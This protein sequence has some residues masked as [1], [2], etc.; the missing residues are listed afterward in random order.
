MYF[1]GSLLQWWL[2]EFIKSLFEYLVVYFI[3]Y[4]N[5]LSQ[6]SLHS[7]YTF[8]IDASKNITLYVKG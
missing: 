8:H 5:D 7:N 3:F 1:T 4:F 2:V 6:T